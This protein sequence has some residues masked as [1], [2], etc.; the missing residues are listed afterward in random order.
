MP[1]EKDPLAYKLHNF[2]GGT[3]ATFDGWKFAPPN[4]SGNW[5][6]LVTS[7]EGKEDDFQ[8]IIFVGT[9]TEQELNQMFELAPQQ[10]RQLFPKWQPR[11]ESKQVTFGGDPG[12]VEDYEAGEWKGKAM[13]LRRST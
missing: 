3:I 13:T 11:G 12:M 7:P 6:V 4:Q 8:M 1:V 10:L 2:N 9:P 5:I